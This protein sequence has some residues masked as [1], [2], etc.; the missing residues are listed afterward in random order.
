MQVA[1]P[2]MYLTELCVLQLLYNLVGQNDGVTMHLK[3]LHIRNEELTIKLVHAIKEPCWHIIVCMQKATT[4]TPVSVAASLEAGLSEN[5]TGMEGAAARTLHLLDGV[6]HLVRARDNV[7][8]GVRDVVDGVWEILDGVLDVLDG[9]RD[10]CIWRSDGVQRDDGVR[11]LVRARDDMV[12]GVRDVVNGVWDILDGVRD[13]LDGFRDDR[14]WRNDGVQRDDEVQQRDL[15][16]RRDDGVRQLHL[17]VRH[18]LGVR[19]D[20]G[21]RCD[22]QVHRGLLHGATEL[23]AAG[24]YGVRRRR[25][26]AA[27]ACVRRAART[28]GRAARDI[29]GRA[30]CE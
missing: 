12:D 25:R 29:N 6:R 5:A 10:D 18:D 23:E 11:H 24:L 4:G 22:Q 3:F 27:A 7:V 14:I 8:D 9:L 30:A 26:Y 21:V 20:L 16:V 13:V 19:R 1:D 28:N 17:G 15:G 2:T